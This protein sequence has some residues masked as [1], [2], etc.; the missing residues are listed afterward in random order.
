MSEII[1]ILNGDNFSSLNTF[2]DEV[3]RKFTK[4]L[5]GKLDEI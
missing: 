2:Y 5:I 4:I 1:V 3:E